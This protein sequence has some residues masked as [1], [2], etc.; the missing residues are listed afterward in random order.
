MNIAVY[1][2]L[3]VS[4]RTSSGDAWIG[5]RREDGAWRHVAADADAAAVQPAAAS[6]LA[7]A[8]RRAVRFVS[9]AVDARRKHLARRVSFFAVL[10]SSAVERAA[11]HTP[12]PGPSAFRRADVLRG[13]VVV[14]AWAA[15]RCLIVRALTDTPSQRARKTRRRHVKFGVFDC[16]QPEST[17]R[18]FETL[19]D[20]LYRPYLSA[21]VHWT[22][23][24]DV[25][26]GGISF[27]YRLSL[28][29]FSANG[30]RRN[31]RSLHYSSCIASQPL[32]VLAS[33]GLLDSVLL[34]PS[35]AKR[36]ECKRTNTK[37]HNR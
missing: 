28:H 14:V 31:E 19:T 3:L 10:R 9:V 15:R 16:S 8:S 34:S 18:S 33:L 36:T 2:T 13:P 23:V 37:C 4:I 20:C 7:A 35:C 11:R 22:F 6:Q 5:K 21:T 32:F 26:T 25:G 27:H 1:A 12:G 24:R 29:K 17:S 30:E